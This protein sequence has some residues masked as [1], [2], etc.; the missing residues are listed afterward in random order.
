VDKEKVKD[1]L[2]HDGIEDKSDTFKPKEE[3]N[4]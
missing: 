4:S 2:V 1:N 3:E